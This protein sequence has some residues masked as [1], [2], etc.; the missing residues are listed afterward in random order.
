MFR[1]DQE[2]EDASAEQRR[3][4]AVIARE[5]IVSEQVPIA[6]VEEEFRA[7]Y[8]VSNFPVKGVDGRTVTGKEKKIAIPDGT[9]AVTI[10]AATR[11][12]LVAGA[13]VFI[14]RKGCARPVR[15][16]GGRRQKWRVYSPVSHVFAGRTRRLR[17]RPATA[18][19]SVSVVPPFAHGVQVNKSSWIV[20]QIS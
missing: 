1:R 8:I 12:D 7:G 6:G 14:G 10:A 20:N 17:V 15:P 13:V 18:T 16:S 5:R 9:P 3:C 2:F 11:D 4:L 19:T